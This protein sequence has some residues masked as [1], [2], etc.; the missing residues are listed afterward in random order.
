ML[1]PTFCGKLFLGDP[2]SS[3]VDDVNV[4]VLG[5]Y[6]AIRR[7]LAPAKYRRL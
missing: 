3:F 1:N 5:S 2:F 7:I 6:R 4:A